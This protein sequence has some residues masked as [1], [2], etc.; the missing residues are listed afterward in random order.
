ME[1][2]C[3]NCQSKLNIPDSKIPKDKKASFL[4]PKCKERIYITPK[5]A[6]KKEDRPNKSVPPA[7]TE[8]KVAAGS[9]YDASERPFDY[10]DEDARTAL[11]CID[12]A[13]ILPHA[14]TALEQLQFHMEAVPD[15]ETALTRM[16]YHL[17]N[18]VLVDEAFNHSHRGATLLLQELRE[19]DMVLR[20]QMV[21][22]LLSEKLRTQDDMAA[23]NNSVNQV[24]N[25]KDMVTHAPQLLGKIIKDHEQRYSVFNETLKKAGKA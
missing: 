18:I 14:R 3:T 25:H 8:E 5:G 19:L 6:E 9:A 13:Q 16:K 21:V 17:F 7:P 20:R 15:V 10:L 12:N 2:T 4:C 11:I 1:I 23:L 22:V 24:I